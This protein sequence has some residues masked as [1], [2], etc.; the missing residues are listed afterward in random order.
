MEGRGD[1]LGVEMGFG[2]VAFSLILVFFALRKSIASYKL[3]ERSWA[4][5]L[6]LVP[7]IL[8]GLFWI[9]MIAGE[10]LYPH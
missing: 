2:L 7:S 3:G 1:K 5:W 9:F 6:G 8:I 10:I 4:M